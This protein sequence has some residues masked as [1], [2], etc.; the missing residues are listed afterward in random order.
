M[1][2]T[3]LD[4]F[5]RNRDWLEH[6]WKIAA[7]MTPALAIFLA[8]ILVGGGITHIEPD[9]ATMVSR[10]MSKGDW[11]VL[12]HDKPTAIDAEFVKASKQM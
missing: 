12:C 1:G 4:F 9:D 8:T 10:L 2:R 7:L 6:K 3:D 11:L 5:L